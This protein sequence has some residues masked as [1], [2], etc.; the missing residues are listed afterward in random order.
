MRKRKVNDVR[1]IQASKSNPQK[2]EQ[3]VS[4]LF[5]E[6][7]FDTISFAYIEDEAHKVY[8]TASNDKIACMRIGESN[9]FCSFVLDESTPLIKDSEYGVHTFV[10]KTKQLSNEAGL[11]HVEYDLFMQDECVDTITMTWEI[12]NN[13][14]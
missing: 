1:V 4:L 11:F 9:T 2:N 14:K 13:E 7:V 10:S 3:V 6:Q 8:I 12:E 5:Y